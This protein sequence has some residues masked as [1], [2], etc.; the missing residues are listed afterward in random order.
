MNQPNRPMA[1]APKDGR[2]IVV[3]ATSV[4]EYHMAWNPAAEN[5]LWAPGVVGMWES[6]DQSCTWA[7]HEGGGPEWWR[8]MDG[9]TM[10]VPPAR[11][12]GRN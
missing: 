10:P 7:D 5:P 8:P 12:L 9:C 1:E 6:A 4:G 2:I 11:R 3:G